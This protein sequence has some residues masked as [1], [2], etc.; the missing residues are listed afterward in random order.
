MFSAACANALHRTF[1]SKY[2]Q[3]P[4][5]TSLIVLA[6]NI[7]WSTWDAI[8]SP[9]ELIATKSGILFRFY[10]IYCIKLHLQLSAVA[11]GIQMDRLSPSTSPSSGGTTP[12]RRARL[13]RSERLHS[14]S[15]TPYSSWEALVRDSFGHIVWPIKIT[16][17]ELVDGSDVVPTR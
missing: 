16:S 14:D 12:K 1:Y 8:I 11:S 7:S 10:W 3:K 9:S 17:W 4:T 5:T 15:H 13:Q 6:L 2:I